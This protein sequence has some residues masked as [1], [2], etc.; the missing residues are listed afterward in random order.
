MS[1]WPHLLRPP[2]TTPRQEPA[3]SLADE[4]RA[5]LSSPERLA[6]LVGPI[7]EAMR[8]ARV[9]LAG[10]VRGTFAPKT[11]QREEPPAREEPFPVGDSAAV[12]GE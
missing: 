8:G 7:P 4:A 10:V 1:H 11:A 6:A 2:P 9:M 12:P 3:L 5:L